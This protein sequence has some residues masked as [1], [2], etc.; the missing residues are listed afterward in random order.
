MSWNRAQF[1]LLLLGL[2]LLRQVSPPGGFGLVVLVALLALPCAAVAASHFRR[3]SLE[4]VGA[5]V[6]GGALCGLAL[7]RPELWLQTSLAAVL[8]LGGG[9]AQRWLRQR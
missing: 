5:F 8:V 7:Q 2:C 6:C 4:W 3:P 1:A 9:T